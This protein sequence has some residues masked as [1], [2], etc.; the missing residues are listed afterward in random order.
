MKAAVLHNFG[1]PL[2]VEQ[3]TD[4]AIGTAIPLYPQVL[5]ECCNAEAYRSVPLHSIAAAIPAARKSERG[6]GGMLLRWPALWR[7]VPS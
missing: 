1:I 3:V 6:S 5:P 2:S 7:G 4:P